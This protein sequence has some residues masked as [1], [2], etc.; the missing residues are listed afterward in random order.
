[1]DPSVHAEGW[2]DAVPPKEPMTLYGPDDKP[3]AT[4]APAA[5]PVGHYA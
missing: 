1:M 4:K 5:V 2:V 3:I